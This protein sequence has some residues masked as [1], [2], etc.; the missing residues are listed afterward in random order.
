MNIRETD[1]QPAV[2]ETDNHKI[3]IVT[4]HSYWDKPRKM[5]KL[6]IKY[7]ETWFSWRRATHAEYG[8]RELQE[9]A[10]QYNPDEGFFMTHGVGHPL[11]EFNDKQIGEHTYKGI[12]LEWFTHLAKDDS[13]LYWNFG[14]NHRNYS[15]AFGYKIFSKNLASWVYE[16]L[17]CEGARAPKRESGSGSYPITLEIPERN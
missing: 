12:P 7:G 15:G 11:R 16:C 1:E 13:D 6:Y 10:E 8:L 5:Y 17:I 3:T 2:E 4:I 14:G 9:L